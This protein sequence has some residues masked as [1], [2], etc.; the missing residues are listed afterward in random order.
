MNDSINLV[1]N[2]PHYHKY[3]LY[4]FLAQLLFIYFFLKY[5]QNY[6]HGSLRLGVK[7]DVSF[8][9]NIEPI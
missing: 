5:I 8:R 2:K 7:Q 9:D 3:Y 6:E 4:R 1:D